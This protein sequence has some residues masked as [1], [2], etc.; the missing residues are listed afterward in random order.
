MRSSRFVS[1]H[2]H[3]F[4]DT[5][6]LPYTM[7]DLSCESAI[8]DEKRGAD[9]HITITTTPPIDEK[10]SL[11]LSLST[12]DSSPITPTTPPPP[13]Y[14]PPHSPRYSHASDQSSLLKWSPT[15]RSTAAD[16]KFAAERRQ[17]GARGGV[18]ED[19]ERGGIPPP[20]DG[21]Y[22]WVCVLS[23]FLINA[24]SWGV[25]SVSLPALPHIFSCHPTTLCQSYYPTKIHNHSHNQTQSDRLPSPTAST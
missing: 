18:T 2:S 8:A 5:K 24:F 20:P 12:A 14:S 23:C 25:V 21:G 6:H 4:F 16:V 19:G 1:L 22:G 3:Q 13:T 7:V 11:A 15:A 10:Q 17:D 9:I